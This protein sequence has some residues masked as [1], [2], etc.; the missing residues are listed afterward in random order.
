MTMAL[1]LSALKRSLQ[2]PRYGSI[3]LEFSL[4]RLNLLQFSAPAADGHCLV[5]AL[6]SAP[7]P[8]SDD[9]ETSPRE[10]ILQSPQPLAAALRQVFREQPFKGRRVT[11]ALPSD[12]LRTFSLR[13]QLQPGQG[14]ADAIRQQLSERLQ[15]DLSDLVIDYVPT[16]HAD[17]SRDRRVIVAAARRDE[18]LGYLDLLARCGLEV[19]ALEIAQVAIKRLV[20]TLNA[21]RDNHN[22]LVINFGSRK[23]Y[24]T[25]VSGR[26]LLFDHSIDFGEQQLLARLSRELDIAPQPL[27][28][29]ML[30]EPHNESLPEQERLRRLALQVLLPEWKELHQEIHRSL[31]FGASELHGS[32]I[33]CIYLLGSLARWQGVPEQLNALVEQPVLL[34]DP[35]STFGGDA[36]SDRVRKQDLCI[37]SGLALK[38]L[39][40]DA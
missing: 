34:P 31:V 13:F 24:L 8:P 18:V 14:E 5:H 39:V 32:G 38:Q 35:L 37:A 6:A 27:R 10:R 21:S 9:S 22:S 2:R 17:D 16:R 40:P 36:F 19:N 3:G 33:A 29:L 4:G 26:R 20:T 23:S 15:E 30:A 25:M 7:Y 11:T 28:Q 12:W 1:P